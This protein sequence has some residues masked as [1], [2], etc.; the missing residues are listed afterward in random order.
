[1]P[2]VS[3]RSCIFGD[4]LRM[5]PDIVQT[6]ADA[7]DVANHGCELCRSAGNVVPVILHAVEQVHQ[8]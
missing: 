5:G 4:V 7:D 6:F 2:T 1:M 3:E 8:Q